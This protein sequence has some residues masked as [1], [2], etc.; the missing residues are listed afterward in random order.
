MVSEEPQGS[1][2]EREPEV[3]VHV[4]EA[5][6]APA[7]PTVIEERS[8]AWFERREAP[9]IVGLAVL[10]LIALLFVLLATTST[11]EAEAEPESGTATTAAADA[12]WTAYALPVPDTYRTHT[13]DVA[14]SV[15]ALSVAQLGAAQ[16]FI[17]SVAMGDGPTVL[18]VY[19]EQ[20]FTLTSPS[21]AMI[22]AFMPYQAAG[23]PVP[24]PGVAVTFVGTLMP[25]PEDFSSFAGPEVAVLGAATGV[26]VRVV[27]ETLT[28]ALPGSGS[29]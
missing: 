4:P 1:L 14:G 24:S 2:V 26:Y 11:V 27:P 16:S 28:L 8:P 18:D 20:T 22:V 15:D 17:G 5:E 3:I 12:T 9:F 21:G 6:P 25:V 13:V 23:A 19:S 10:A 7:A 29:D